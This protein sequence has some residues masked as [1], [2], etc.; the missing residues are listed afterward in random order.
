MWAPSCGAAAVHLELLL[1]WPQCLR[2]YSSHILHPSPSCSCMAVSLPLPHSPRVHSTSHS[3][4][5]T[6]QSQRRWAPLGAAGTALLRHGVGL[7]SAH[8]GP[9]VPSLLPKPCYVSPIHVEKF[10]SIY[11][12]VD[13]LCRVHCHQIGT[14]LNGTRESC[15]IE[16]MFR[17]ILRIT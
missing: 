14:S 11:L 13:N 5:H 15:I 12:F 16:W 7:D 6:A 9:S 8:R 10:S 17:N 4:S 1:H 3:V 2:G